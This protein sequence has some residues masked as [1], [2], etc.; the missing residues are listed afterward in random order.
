MIFV[1][2]R[3][4]ACFRAKWK[5]LFIIIHQI[6]SLVRDWSKHVTW[7][8]IPQLKLGY[9]RVILPNFQNRACCE[10]R[11]K[12]NTQ[13]ASIWREKMLGYLSLDII[14]SPKLTVRFS[15]QIMSKDKYPSIFP[16]QMED[17]VFII[18]QIS[19]ATLAVLKIGEYSGTFP[20][21]SWG[22]F[23]HVTCLDQSRASENIWWIIMLNIYI[24]IWRNGLDRLVEPSQCK[25]R[26]QVRFSRKK[27]VG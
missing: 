23:G 25:T 13:I 22:I 1:W 2:N 24:C 17:I 6:F 3:C 18:L 9:I 11:F 4:C 5:L 20:S 19:F 12:N 15:E 7:L 14:C 16:P 26:F 27:K 8:N 10:K 21:F